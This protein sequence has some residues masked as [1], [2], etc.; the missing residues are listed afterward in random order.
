MSST[1]DNFG[2]KCPNAE[3]RAEGPNDE[4]EYREQPISTQ[5]IYFAEAEDEP[6]ISLSDCEYEHNNA[7]NPVIVC[8]TCWKP[9]PV[10]KAFYDAQP[11][12]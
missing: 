7:E 1:T 2:I 3:C 12:G 10:P 8:R 9:F 6:P 11:W 5:R 4:F